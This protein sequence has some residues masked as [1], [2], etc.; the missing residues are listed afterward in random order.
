M[1]SDTKSRDSAIRNGLDATPEIDPQRSWENL[2]TFKQSSSSLEWTDR[3]DSRGRQT[4][5]L[6]DEPVSFLDKIKRIMTSR[7]RRKR[8]IDAGTPRPREESIQ[9]QRKSSLDIEIQE[10][11]EFVAA[12]EEWREKASKRVRVPKR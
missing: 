2:R 8:S 10:D 1:G 7:R 3:A 12:I 4:S 11:E 5:M 9:L 6:S